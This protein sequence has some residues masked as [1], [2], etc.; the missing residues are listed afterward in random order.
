MSSTFYHLIF[1]ILEKLYFWFEKL[2]FCSLR[3]CK[4]RWLK[5]QLLA[6]K[7]TTNNFFLIFLL[8]LALNARPQCCMRALKWTLMRMRVFQLWGL[9]KHQSTLFLPLSLSPSLSKSLFYLS[10][11]SRNVTKRERVAWNYYF[12]RR[13]DLNVKHGTLLLLMRIMWWKTLYF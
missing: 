5:W 11:S 1:L 6:A 10:L 3:Q 7:S 4:K 13:E 2:T 9:T 12:Q 8:R